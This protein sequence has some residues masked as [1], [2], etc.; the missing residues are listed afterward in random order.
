MAF[1]AVFDYASDV[2]REK[3]RSDTGDS[4]VKDDRDRYRARLAEAKKKKRSELVNAKVFREEVA[5]NSTVKTL[6]GPLQVLPAP[7]IIT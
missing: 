1:H 3:D 2:R 4:R 5:V 7:S 6:L